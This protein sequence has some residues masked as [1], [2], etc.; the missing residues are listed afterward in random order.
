MTATALRRSRPST[1][2]KPTRAVQGMLREVERAMAKAEKAAD[3]KERAA[4]LATVRDLTSKID[5]IWTDQIDQRWI[6]LAITESAQLERERGGTV[7]P[8]NGAVRISNHDGFWTLIEAGAFTQPQIDAGMLYRAGVEARQ[9]LGSQ[10]GQICQTGGEHDNDGFVRARCDR[11]R[12]TSHVSVV[13]R[14]VALECR[15]EPAALQT[16]RWV[17]G[18]SQSISAL[19]K[20]R[21]YTRHVDALVRALDVASRKAMHTRA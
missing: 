21:A 9:P 5:A 10:M 15:D 20:G 11:A 8:F 18:A 6:A 12:L 7:V 17:V 3:R 13:E 1:Q 14:A 19:G 16:L 2:I 4:A